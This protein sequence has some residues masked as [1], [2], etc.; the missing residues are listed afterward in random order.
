MAKLGKADVMTINV[1]DKKGQSHSQTARTLGVTEGA[2]RYHLRR[3]KS[4][5]VDGRS[6]T[7]LI[8]K[9]GLE[10]VVQEWWSAQEAMQGTHRP[11]NLEGLFD[12]L[13]GEYSYPGS[14]KSVRRYVRD[15]YPAPKVRP[16][17]RVETPPGAQ[18]Q[19]D[20]GEFT[21]DIGGSNGPEKIHAFAMV[22]SHSR[23]TAIVWSRSENQLAWHRC[24]NQAYQRLGGVAASNRIDN[25]K[26]GV[27]RGSGPW[28]GI[29]PQYATYAKTMGFHIDPCEAYSPEQKGK[30]ERRV[31]VLRQLDVSG[32]CFESLEHL[33]E[34]T[35]AKL[36]A[37]EQRR[38]CPV[39]GLSVAESWAAE[40]PFLK[41]LPELLPEPF[42]LVK[43]CVVYK[44]CSIRF[45]GRTYIVPFQYAERSVEVRGCSGFI[46]IVDRKNGQIVKSYPRGT[47]ARLL[48]DTKCYEGKS[49]AE[50]EAPKPLGRMARK[51]QEIMDTPV[52]NRPLD[53]YAALAEVAR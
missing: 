22:L 52:Q 29:N 49:T 42:D 17:R 9:Q 51:L 44:D 18:S 33:Q 13:K 48:I 12:F 26:T 36:L 15:K 5:S 8:Q 25:L 37:L 4:C 21:I 31:G 39:T 19:S 23:K 46:Q 6:K 47:Q 24:H 2:V 10:A 45:E 3:A 41:A 14:Y 53:L 20:W 7:F 40:K 32:R 38:I 28:S 35:D 50:V 16:F 1:L 27:S 34:W 11:P 30:I 43:D